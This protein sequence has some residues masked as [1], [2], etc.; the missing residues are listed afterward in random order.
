MSAAP[1]RPFDALQHGPPAPPVGTDLPDTIAD[2]FDPTGP[3]DPPSLVEELVST[4]TR[5]TLGVEA[6]TALL[7]GAQVL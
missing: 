4:R 6:P 5:S 3:V 2:P 7:L 1:V